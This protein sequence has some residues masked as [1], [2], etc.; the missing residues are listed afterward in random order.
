MTNK[1]FLATQNEAKVERFKALIAS[2]GLQ[3]DF[4]TPKDLGLENVDAAETGATL[5]DN[6]EIKARAYFGQVAMPILANDTGF[7]VEGEGLIDAPKRTAL[8]EADEQDLSKEQIAEA[9]LRFWKD[10]AGKHGGKVD[11]AWV[12]VFVLLMP[13]GLLHSAESR[14]EVILTDQEF[15]DA[16]I[17][18]P[19]RALYI[20]KST[21]KP[22]IQHSPEE[23]LV[24]MKPV[25]DALRRVLTA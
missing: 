5:A 6:A 20:S 18:M 14:R 17:Q 24:E 10:V 9:L 12:E 3:F 23:E 25:S 15:G 7:W 22:S 2:T 19:V 16:H 21:N 1:L 13:D 11:A 4:F 8:G